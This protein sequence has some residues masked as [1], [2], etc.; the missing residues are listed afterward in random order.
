MSL[1]YK[2]TLQTTLGRLRLGKNEFHG[3]ALAECERDAE[4]EIFSNNNNNKLFKS[5]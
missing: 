4:G 5:K 3:L 2:P 1:C